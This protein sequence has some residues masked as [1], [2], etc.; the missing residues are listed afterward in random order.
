MMP[1]L[2]CSLC[3]PV[4]NIRQHD[5]DN[6]LLSNFFLWWLFKFHGRPK[7]NQGHGQLEP[8]N[9]ALEGKPAS[10]HEIQLTCI[11]AGRFG[12]IS[13]FPD[14]KPVPD[15]DIGSKFAFYLMAQRKF[16]RICL[17][18]YADIKYSLHAGKKGLNLFLCQ[19]FF[20]R[21][22]AGLVQYLI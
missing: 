4:D 13:G 9:A 17:M 6:I 18:S 19:F 12:N 10:C 20:F 11:G 8:K 7:E 3:P 22:D 14:K 1:M 2:Y 21:V 16:T 15:T 5:R